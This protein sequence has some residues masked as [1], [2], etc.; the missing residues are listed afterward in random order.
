MRGGGY[1]D[2]VNASSGPVN[3]PF[4]Q[5]IVLAQNSANVPLL[6]TSLDLGLQVLALNQLPPLEA[7]PLSL[8]ELQAHAK[9]HQGELLAPAPANQTTLE[10]QAP[11]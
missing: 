7:R 2:D 9:A 10:Y 5:D 1:Y 11:A 6:E 4:I 3:K 8:A